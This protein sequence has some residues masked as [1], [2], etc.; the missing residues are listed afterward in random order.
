MYFHYNKS[1]TELIFLHPY[2]RKNTLL[3]DFIAFPS[4]VYLAMQFKYLYMCSLQNIKRSVQIH[5]DTF[6]S[7]QLIL[8][9]DPDMER[10]NSRYCLLTVNTFSAF[11]I[12]C[13][14]VVSVVR[15]IHFP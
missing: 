5:L 12:L 10:L 7:R 8:N 6:S 15:A 13:G 3:S 2:T 1:Q 14:K 11:M 9:N 4:V